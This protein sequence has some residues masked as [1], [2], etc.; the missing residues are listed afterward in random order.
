MRGQ[1]LWAS[2]VLRLQ[3]FV[4]AQPGSKGK[5]RRERSRADVGED[6]PDSDGRETKKE[7]RRR[8]ERR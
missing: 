3:S 1:D 7:G 2:R 4:S 8:V 6:P 5:V